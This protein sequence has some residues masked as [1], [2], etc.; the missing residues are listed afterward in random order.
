MRKFFDMPDHT[1]LQFES[2][3]LREVDKINFHVSNAEIIERIALKF[4]VAD[5]VL[6]LT[7]S[8]LNSVYSK[9]IEPAREY[10]Y[11]Y[12]DLPETEKPGMIRTSSSCQNQGDDAR[13]IEACIDILSAIDEERVRRKQLTPNVLRT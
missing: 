1:D 13:F 9:L 7:D 11:Y 10:G 12:G 8:F 2:V 6:G 4:K 5:I 3:L